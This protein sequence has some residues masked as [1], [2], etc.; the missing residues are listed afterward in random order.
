[1]TSETIVVMT[2]LEQPEA[3][4]ELADSLIESRLAACVQVLG[5]IQSTY[6]WQGKVESAREWLALIKTRGDLWPAVE[7]HIRQRHSYETPE[8]MA[9][10]AAAVS[11]PYLAWL[12]RE[13]H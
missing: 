3:A 13:T 8:I 1:M 2:T 5:P 11:Q 12:M 9:L 7:R 4:Q 6:R 10:P